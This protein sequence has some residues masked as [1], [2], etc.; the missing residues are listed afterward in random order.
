LIQHGAQIEDDY[1]LGFVAKL[2]G[3]DAQ[4]PD[5]HLAVQV[6]PWARQ[7]PI[8]IG[9][10]AVTGPLARGKCIVDPAAESQRQNPSRVFRPARVCRGLRV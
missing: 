5:V 4:L 10:L 2:W 6:D 8:A 3:P 9:A 1:E 7:K